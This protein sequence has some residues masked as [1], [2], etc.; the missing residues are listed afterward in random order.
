META[1]G[2]GMVFDEIHRLP[3]RVRAKSHKPRS[4]RVRIKQ[5]PLTLNKEIEKSDK[6][7]SSQARTK[8]L[9]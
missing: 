1:K 3:N 2:I 9:K 7:Y 5:T 4:T 8:G 6:A